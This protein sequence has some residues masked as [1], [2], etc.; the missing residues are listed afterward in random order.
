MTQVALEAL[1]SVATEARIGSAAARRMAE[2]VRAVGPELVEVEKLLAE[3]SRTGASPGTEAA[4]HLLGAGGKRIRP[5][6]LLLSASI[7]AKPTRRTHELA[8]V[9][10]L[11]HGATLL[12]D[13]VVDDAPERRG[14]AAA[15]TVWGNAVSVLGGDLMLTHALARCYEAGNSL[16]FEHLL[17]TLRTLV[18]GE[19]VQ[20]RGRT[21][22]DLRA[23]TYFHIANA[24]TA[25]LFDWATTSGARSA[26]APE[27]HALALGRFGVNLGLAF[28]LV[29]DV[30]DYAG[31]SEVTGKALFADLREGKITLPLVYA[32]E[33]DPRLEV[34]VKA[35]RAGEES[36]ALELGPA[37]LATNA[38]DRVRSLA[39]ER[40]RNALRELH[41]LPA[42]EPRDLLG[43]V[44]TDLVARLH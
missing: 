38:C 18:D 3:S 6:A 35:V 34:L 40:T 16:I 2:V 27:E 33:S 42:S 43:A 44:A 31:T 14:Q 10:E 19:I 28:Q 8:A 20:L 1:G 30:L 13:D 29:D 5:V 9:A 17:R 15:R 12:H 32:L 37:I 24:K 41:G 26:G 4:A 11:V 25:S 36:A 22:L 39:Q 7:Y 21:A 23:E